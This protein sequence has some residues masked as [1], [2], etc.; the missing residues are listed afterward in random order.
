MLN[1]GI[2]LSS[3]GMYEMEF[4]TSTKIEHTDELNRRILGEV[5]IFKIHC[6]AVTILCDGFLKF[7]GN[8]GLNAKSFKKCGF[9]STYQ[10]N[11]NLL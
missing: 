5:I 8:F 7:P 6:N 4:E 3:L 11:Q 10:L 9:I 1:F 2:F